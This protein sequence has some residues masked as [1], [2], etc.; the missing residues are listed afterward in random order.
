MCFIENQTP[1]VYCIPLP[2][3]GTFTHYV[4]RLGG[5]GMKNMT[6]ADV[7]IGGGGWRILSDVS[8]NLIPIFTI[9]S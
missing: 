5:R 1:G 6:V 8:R 7:E 4:S 9:S 3:R 2:R